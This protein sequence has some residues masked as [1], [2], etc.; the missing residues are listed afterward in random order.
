MQM[1]NHF[2]LSH[3]HLV[4]GVYQD[5]INVTA[6]HQSAF[7]EYL[8][9]TM[10]PPDVVFPPNFEYFGVTFGLSRG[11][12]GF[13]NLYPGMANDQLTHTKAGICFKVDEAYGLI[14][15]GVW[16]IPSDQILSG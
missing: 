3:N 13:K 2:F 12:F 5:K 14:I 16:S 4:H 9:R 8:S 10:R 1:L 11:Y 7:Q 6:T 15:N